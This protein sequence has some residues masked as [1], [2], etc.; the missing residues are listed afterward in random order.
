MLKIPDGDTSK[1]K[2]QIFKIVATSFREP[3]KIPGLYDLLLSYIII[4]TINM[5]DVLNM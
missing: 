1:L 3:V 5:F 2:V 4:S